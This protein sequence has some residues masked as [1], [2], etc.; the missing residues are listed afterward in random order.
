MKYYARGSQI[1]KRF[2]PDGRSCYF[3]G[4]VR[5]VS[6][7]DICFERNMGARQNIYLIYILSPAKD[8]EVCYSLPEL[9]VKS[10][11]LNLFG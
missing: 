4:G 3:R 7:R 11:Y 2:P 6:I 8:R 5:V 10:V 1:V 9:Y